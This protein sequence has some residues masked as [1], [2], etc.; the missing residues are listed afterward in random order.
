MRAQAP[1]EHARDRRLL[2]AACTI[3]FALAGCG[4]RAE[5]RPNALDPDEVPFGL[6]DAGP[7]ASE[8]EQGET[9]FTVYFL[10]SEGRL[11]PALRTRPERTGPNQALRR[12]LAGPT[13]AEAE[14]GLATAI[15]PGTDAR[16]AV[17]AGDLVV[18]ELAG[19]LVE[20]NPADAVAAVA[21]LV[22]TVTEPEG[23]GRLLFRVDGKAVEIPRGDGTLTNEPVARADYATLGS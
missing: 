9:P 13:V 11:V 5:S 2:L 17:V 10:D 18:V 7:V 3:A 4:V 6:L 23:V 14:S 22:F 1:G 21:Q 12:L 16:A 19:S 20:A 15:P 8:P